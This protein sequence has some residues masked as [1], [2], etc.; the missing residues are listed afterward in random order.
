MGKLR[1]ALLGHF[2]LTGQTGPIDLTNKKLA[3]LMAFLSL[4]APEPQSREKLMALLWG[5][6]FEAQAR[7]NLRQALTRLRRALGPS[8][9]ISNG[10]TVSLSPDAIVCDVTRFETLV[11]H[12]SRDALAEAV[13]LYRDR[14]LANIDIQQEAWTEWADIQRNRLE[15]LA[16]DAMIKLGEY[17]LQSGDTESALEVA[18]RALTL[19]SLREDA[20]RLIIRALTAS[21]RRGEALRHYDELVDL[22]KRQLDVQPDS[23]TRKL[24]DAVRAETSQQ[25][26]PGPT[27]PEVPVASNALDDRIPVEVNGLGKNEMGHGQGVVYAAAIDPSAP[28]L[29]EAPQLLQ[30]SSIYGGRLRPVF[31][32]ASTLLLLGAGIVTWQLW[33]ARPEIASIER[34]AF[35]LPD[36]PSI[37]VLP[38]TNLSSEAVQDLT[39][40]GLTE[41]LVNALARNPSLFVIAHASTATY[42]GQSAS[43]KQVAEELGVRYILEGSVKRAGSSVRVTTQLVDSLSG[44]VLWSERYDR[45][46][47]D[48]LA[49]EDDVTARIAR[50]LDV[51][52]VYGTEQSPG[53]THRLDA[54]SAYLEG[55]T[56]YLKFTLAGNTR[57]REHFLRALEFDPTY[58]EATLAL[59]NTYFVEMTGTPKDDW[60][61]ALATITEL[62]RQAAQIAPRMPRL[63]ELRSMLAMTRGDYDS[64][65]EEAESM[66]EVDPNGADSHYVLGRMY[67]FIAQYESAIEHLKTAERINPHSRASYSAHLAFSYLALGQLDEAVSMLEAVAKRW[68]DYSSATAYLAILYQLAGQE[69]EARQQLVLYSRLNPQ[70]TMLAVEQRF[71]PMRDRALADRII[72][73]A[74]QVGIPD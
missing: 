47:D 6:H 11:D 61:S 59:A 66:V 70:L 18:H 20:H 19:N 58:A 37:A 54:W 43:P 48:L 51:R 72:S 40:D 69:T 29:T 25:Q 45:I 24:V 44:R 33:K 74:R 23:I 9:L 27:A 30:A 63:H 16:L 67:F 73:A 57:A 46:A 62:D 31:L 38:F 32:A 28:P 36:K 56:E 55:R 34:M 14:F 49:I 65:L 5:S 7:Q 50:S 4:H 53:G 52:I 2:E 64:A 3:G 26:R 10:E 39:S 13:D 22:L 60:G 12:G 41:S 1:L 35:P 42:A 15:G 17:E 21:G 71:S 68:P 8:A